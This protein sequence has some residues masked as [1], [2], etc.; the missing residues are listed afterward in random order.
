MEKLYSVQYLRGMAALLVVVSHAF[1]H[2]IGL[3][4]PFVVF[5]GQ[6]GVT[7][8]FVIS[9]FIMVYISGNQS[10][11]AWNF[12]T[13]RAARIVP[14]YWL[15]TALAALLALFLPSLFKT[16][17]FTWP[18]LLQSLF[19]IVHEAPGRGGSSPLLSLGW[20]L[21]YEAYFY[22]TFAALA[23]FSAKL[24]VSILTVLFV[25]LWLWGALAPST[26]PVIQF[27]L[28]LSPL[29]FALGSWA[30]L[31][32]LY[33]W[34]RQSRR[35]VPVLTVMG[36]GGL[37]LALANTAT[38]DP[39][40]GFMGQMALAVSLLGLGLM[41]EGRSR[42]SRA[43]ALLGDASYAI[44]LTHMF[45]IGAALGLLERLVPLDNAVSVTV[46]AL[47]SVVLALIVGIATHY[48]IEKPLLALVQR[49]RKVKSAGLNKASAGA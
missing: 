24:R 8:F 6:M 28:N 7:L 36:L 3:D 15:F 5:A 4:N 9:G 48:C 44:Y 18:H 10:F 20:T 31:A 45:V 43:L 32:A 27:Y 38:I 16:T 33:G 42:E 2:Q 21:N 34:H 47:G 12:L 46:A 22:V 35:L 1:S 14:L 29:A 37:W 39:T 25:G 17:T 30:G 49:R 26:D 13:R 11:S 40:P 23:I 19:F 41:L